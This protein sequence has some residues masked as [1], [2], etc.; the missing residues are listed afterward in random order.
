[1]H[2]HVN[3]NYEKA[4]FA[5]GNIRLFEATGAGCCQHDHLPHLEEFFIPDKEII[6]QK[7]VR[8]RKSKIS[9]KNPNSQNRLQEED[10]Q[11]GNTTPLKK[12]RRV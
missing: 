6:L 8:S 11:H 3:A 10:M 1:M 7:S 5:A 4:K 9:K 12:S 2:G